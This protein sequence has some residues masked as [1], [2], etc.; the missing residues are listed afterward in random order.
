M[1]VKK[2]KTIHLNPEHK[3]LLHKEMGIKEG[4][5]IS[6]EELEKVKKNASPKKKQ[7]IQFAEN[8]KH[9]N[10]KKEK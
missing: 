7:R 9:F 8:A 4:K 5:K 1:A 3:G 10:H 6:T 2:K